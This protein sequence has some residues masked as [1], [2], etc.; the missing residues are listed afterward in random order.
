MTPDLLFS[1]AFRLVYRV[2]KILQHFNP[3][4][5]GIIPRFPGIEDIHDAA[6]LLK[7]GIWNDGNQYFVLIIEE[8]HR[9]C[10][11]KRIRHASWR[12]A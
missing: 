1:L 2:S 6:K 8:W 10:F 3:D 12:W 5:R 7:R 11:F 9:I 4:K